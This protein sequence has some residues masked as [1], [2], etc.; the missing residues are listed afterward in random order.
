[1]SNPEIPGPGPEETSLPDW[2]QLFLEA[3]ERLQTQDS[4]I[5]EL[6]RKFEDMATRM[7]QV[8]YESFQNANNAANATPPVV[9]QGTYK[10]AHPTPYNGM[11]N[12]LLLWIA[13]EETHMPLSRIT[14]PEHCL[15]VATQF[16]NSDVMTWY[17]CTSDIVNWEQL[18]QAMT[19]YYKP[20]NE[21]VNARDGLKNLRQKRSVAEYA[22]DFNKLV[23][24]LP[25]MTEDEKIYSFISGLQTEVKLQVELHRPND[26]QAAKEIADRADTIIFQANRFSRGRCGP[27]L[28]TASGNWPNHGD[29]AMKIGA[30]RLTDSEREKY[31]KEGK[32]FR[33]GQK[34]HRANQHNVDGS[35]PKN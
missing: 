1:M 3:K 27:S 12:K 16:L 21:Q 25:D 7:R 2:Y 34:G 14:H 5:L 26:L 20:H 35:P 13:Q 15:L 30:A 32:C 19:V 4:T 11:P 33:C 9:F 18:K 24:K 28:E 29:E 6:T 31:M 17:Q 22:N 10:P 8:Q 23:L